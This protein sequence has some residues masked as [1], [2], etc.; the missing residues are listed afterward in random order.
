M[1]DGLPGEKSR[2]VLEVSWQPDL[3]GISSSAHLDHSGDSG[4]SSG[5]GKMYYLLSDHDNRICIYGCLG[6]EDSDRC[7]HESKMVS[8]D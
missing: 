2:K 8:M 3:S 4:V 5:I 7:C 1:A 6:V